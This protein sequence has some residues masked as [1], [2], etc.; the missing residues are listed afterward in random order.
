VPATEAAAPEVNPAPA[1]ESGTILIVRGD[2]NYP[3]YEMTEQEVLTGFHVELVQKVAEQLNIPVQFQSVPWNRALSMMEKG[4]ADAITYIG[5]TPEREKFT[6]FLEGNILSVTRQELIVLESKKAAIQYTGD[7]QALSSY[8]IGIQSGYSYGEAFNAAD[9]LKKDEVKTKEQLSE[10]LAL[11]RLDLI[12]VNYD[13]YKTDL[14]QGLFKDT[15]YLKPDL[16][17]SDNYIGFSKVKNRGDLAQRFADALTAFK[18]T[19]EYQQLLSKYGL[20]E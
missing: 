18:Q 3:P 4:E 8:R 14:Q 1:L 16:N 13:E 11:N 9:Y 12:A 5:K 17:S 20:E 19:D 7:L 6:Y 15:T 10:M 2:E